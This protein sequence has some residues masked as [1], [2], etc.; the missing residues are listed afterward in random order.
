[1]RLRVSI[2][3]W[4]KVEALRRRT[5]MAE[6]LESAAQRWRDGY[7]R[8]SGVHPIACPVC[9]ADAY[10]CREPD[11]FV[12]ANGSAN[13]ACWREILSGKVPGDD[14]TPTELERAMRDGPT[15]PVLP[16]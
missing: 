7:G 14:R 6:V 5:S 15:G 13:A 16:E 2:L 8:G 11:R 12:H 10:Y 1:V 3:E 9:G 4:L